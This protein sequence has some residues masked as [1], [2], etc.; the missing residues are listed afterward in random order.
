MGTY[1]SHAYSRYLIT[2]AQYNY[3]L[4]IYGRCSKDNG[5]SHDCF[6]SDQYGYVFVGTPEDYKDALARIS[7]M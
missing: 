2:E 6:I 7:Y 4:P 5:F 1:T 3:L